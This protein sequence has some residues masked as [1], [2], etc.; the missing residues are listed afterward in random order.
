MRWEQE[1]RAGQGRYLRPVMSDESDKLDPAE[2]HLY[3][4][5]SNGGR[6]WAA[7]LHSAPLTTDGSTLAAKK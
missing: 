3:I 2:T 7:Q 5:N 6:T 4:S 1:A